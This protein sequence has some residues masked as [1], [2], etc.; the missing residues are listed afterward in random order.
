[1]IFPMILAMAIPSGEWE[2]GSGDASDW[3]EIGSGDFIEY[4]ATTTHAPGASHDIQDGLGW[5]LGLLSGIILVICV[6]YCLLYR[7]TRANRFA[8]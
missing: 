3:E 8:L 6:M 1:M 4:D 7:G 2:L 5:G